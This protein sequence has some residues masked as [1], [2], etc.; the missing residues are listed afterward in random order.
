[1]G[2]FSTKT[3]KAASEFPPLYTDDDI[4]ERFKF[5]QEQSGVY[6]EAQTRVHPTYRLAIDPLAMLSVAKS[7][8]D[9]IW[10]Y[11]VYHLNSA[12][13]L[14]DGIKRAAYFTKWLVRHRPIYYVRTDGADVE[15]D[16][17]DTTLTINELFAIHISLVTIATEL[18]VFRIALDPNFL[19]D[20]IY[21]LYF[22]Q[23][24]E[25]ALLHT[26]SIIQNSAIAKHVV[27]KVFPNE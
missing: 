14:S 4:R 23:L 10:R 17:K 16:P 18:D 1:M 5:L 20:F 12:D 19:A 27:M 11:K 7:A 15:F 8:L 3:T 21:N 2:E 25:D 6:L 9:D 22:R 26:Y 13:K 24:T